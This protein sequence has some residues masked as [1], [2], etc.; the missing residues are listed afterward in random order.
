MLVK[1][2]CS[3]GDY[4]KSLRRR[5]LAALAFLALGILGLVCNFGIVQGSNL[6]SYARGFYLGASSGIALGGVILLLRIQYLMTHPEAQKKARIQETDE[7]ERAVVNRS[8][9]FAGLLTFYLCIA[10]MMV[11]VA[12]NMDAALTIFAVIVVYSFSFLCANIFLSKTL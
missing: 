10:A 7:R 3:N 11:L 1:L 2:M 12:V 5:R 6:P 9:Q 4:G 8:F